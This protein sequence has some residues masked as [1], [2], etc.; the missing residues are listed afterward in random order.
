M[1]SG[2]FWMWAMCILGGF[3]LG[4]IMFCQVIPKTFL[5]IDICAVSSDHNPGATNVFLNCGPRWGVL[6]LMLD[7]LKGFVPVWYASH[8]L[9][10]E[11]PLFALVIAAPVL[12]HAMAPFLQFHGGKCIATAFGDL[13]ALFPVCR[14]VLLLAG[15]YI[16]FSAI[17]PIHPNRIR[18]IVTFVLFGS[19]SMVLLFMYHRSAIGMGCG[20]ISLIVTLKHTKY[21]ADTEEE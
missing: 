3:S 4:A 16:L 15:L 20:L 9:P 2:Q 10:V 14:I 1:I 7:L 12:G 17:L 18:S 8:H 19:I 5:G 11:H 21:F 13:L 6:C